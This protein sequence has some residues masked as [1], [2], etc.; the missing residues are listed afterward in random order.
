L[1]TPHVGDGN[2]E[3]ELAPDGDAFRLSGIKYYSTGNAYIDFIAVNA[4][5]TEG[6]KVVV[7]VPTKREGVNT[8]DDWDGIGQRFTASGTTIFDNVRIE[9][10][11]VI[12]SS[13]DDRLLLHEA[14]FPQLYLTAIIAGILRAIVRDA[15][16]LIHSRDRNYYHA[17]AARPA[18]DPLLQQIVGRLAGVAHVAEA[19]V[20]NAAEA[21]GRVHDAAIAGNY[22]PALNE[23]AALRVAKTKIVIDELALDAATKLFDVGGASSVKRARD[24]DRHWRNIRTLSSHNP[25]AYKARAIGL[26]ALDGTPLPTGA[27]F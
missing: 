14:T 3:T 22:D 10:E 12:L 4:T 9:P 2:N 13:V 16:A 17:T 8:D 1:G 20:L 15:A 7:I 5:T 23:E 25:L 11:E 26:N 18:D 21:L 6:Q 24:L 19:A 27:F